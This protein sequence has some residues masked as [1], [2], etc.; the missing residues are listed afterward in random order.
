MSIRRW[1]IAAGCYQ[2]GHRTTQAKR[3]GAKLI[4]YKPSCLG[5]NKFNERTWQ[6]RAWLDEWNGVERWDELQ[7]W[8][9]HPAKYNFNL[10]LAAKEKRK[11]FLKRT[12]ETIFN[13]ALRWAWGREWVGVV[14]WDESRH[15]G[16][17][18]IKTCYLQRRYV[19]HRLKTDPC[20]RLAQY[21]RTRIGD[22]LRYQCAIKS[23]RT[24]KLLGCSLAFLKEHLEA[25]WQNGMTWKNYGSYWEVDHIRPCTSFDLTRIDDQQR[26]FHYTNLQPLTMPQNRA[27]QA[28]YEMR[29][30]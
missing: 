6:R 22:A 4:A 3:D 10:C 30:D 27:K 13:N 1:L 14:K 23:E 17:H 28:K 19:K 18:P 11:P 8:R 16:W 26:C 24:G 29:T 15:W 2:V 7:H 20:F 9:N 12:P 25:Q 5:R 21:M